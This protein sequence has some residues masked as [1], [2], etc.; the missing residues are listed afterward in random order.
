LG[1][2]STADSTCNAA[3]SILGSAAGL[4]G[5]VLEVA[6]IVEVAETAFE[7]VNAAVD[8]AENPTSF[9]HRQRIP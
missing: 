8:T 2:N 1:F 5:D 3:S 9:L 4:A 6:I 7:I